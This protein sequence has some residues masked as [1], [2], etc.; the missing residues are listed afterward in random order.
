MKEGPLILIAH[1]SRDA[2]WNESLRQMTQNLRHSTGKDVSLAFMDFA[3]PDLD[4]LIA[5]Y[6]RQNLSRA[7]LLPLFIADAGHVAR[8]IPEL[9]KAAEEN[10]PGFK[11]EILPAVGAH[12]EFL[13]MMEK[14]IA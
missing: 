14:I 12:P 13:E 6:A 7:K 10:H 2:E 11:I 1:G 3:K 9:V 4:A 8:D 5:S